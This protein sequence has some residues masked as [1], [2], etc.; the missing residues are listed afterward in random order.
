MLA[1]LLRHDSVY[2]PF[3]GDGRGPRRRDPRGRPGDPRLRRDGPRRAAVGR[4]R[5]RGRHRVDRVVPR[6]R[7][8]GQAPRGGRQQG[9][10][11]RAGQGARRHRRAGDQLRARLR[12]GAPPHHLQRV[13]YDQLPGPGG[14]GAARGVR[15]PPRR[16]HHRPRLHVRPAPARR[17]AQ[18]L[19][20]CPQRRA[21]PRADLHRRRQGDRRRDPRARRPPAG[22]RGPRAAGHRLARRPH[23][24]A[25]AR[26]LSPG[27]QPR[28]ARARRPRIADRH[29]VLQRGAARLHRRREVLLLLHLRLR[30]DARDRRH[31]G[32]GHRLVRQR[33][34]LLQPPRRPRPTRARPVPQPA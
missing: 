22:L 25:R 19:P 26:D 21:Q 17:A 2:G 7:G 4:P 30:P 14:Q 23:S 12:P 20:A 9:D 31:A 6:S 28:H 11:L 5:R 3:P 32:Q 1:H 27:R 29:P 24:R 8:G 18:G 34:G 13:V 10:H 16:A 33:V 15:H